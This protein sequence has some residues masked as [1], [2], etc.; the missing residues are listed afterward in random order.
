M[1]LSINLN[2]FLTFKVY[3]QIHTQKIKKFFW[4]FK[5]SNS[6]FAKDLQNFQTQNPNPNTL[7][8]KK[9]KPRLKPFG[10]IG[11]ICLDFLNLT[12]AVNLD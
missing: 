11:C 7:K 3:T 8:I 12:F 10:F 1:D 4:Y 6:K 9:P 5:L 2:F